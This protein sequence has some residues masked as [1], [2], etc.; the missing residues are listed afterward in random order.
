MPIYPKRGAFQVQVDRADALVGYKRIRR[1][2]PT[3]Q[4]AAD[5]EAEINEAIDR[6]GK[7]PVVGGDQPRLVHNV[8][9]PDGTLR[10]A[11]KLAIENHWGGTPYEKQVTPVVWVMVEFLEATR[12]RKDLD[13]ITSEDIEAYIRYCFEERGSSANTVNHHLSALST[14]NDI[15]LDRKPPLCTARLPIKRVKVKPIEKWW[16][17]PEDLEK[18]VRWLE[19]QAEYVFADYLQTLA[20]EGL[21]VAEGLRLRERHITGLGSEKPRLKVPGTK[22]AESQSTIPVFPRAVPVLER[23]IERAQTM[24]WDLLFPMTWRHANETWKQVRAVLG[25]TDV[26]TATLQ[27][28]RRSFAHYANEQGMPTKTLQK[29]LRHGT[30]GTTDKYLQL[31]GGTDAEDA[32]RYFE[33]EPGVEKPEGWTEVIA[34]YKSTGATPAEVAQF[35]KELMRQ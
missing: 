33:V 2:R 28:V 35:V 10:A 14:I 25:V 19:T 5:L 27:S 13:A 11:A 24:E 23:S 17:R 20:F 15:A 18:A 34:A 22:T 30:I 29:V 26:R 9:L 6:Y 1:S 3:Y 16:L 4:Q 31:V 7:W 12:K 32:R 21:R 8:T